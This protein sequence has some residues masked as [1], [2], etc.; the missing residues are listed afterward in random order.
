[1]ASLGYDPWQSEYLSERLRKQNVP[2]LAVQFIS[3]NLQSMAQAML[4]S[5]NQHNIDLYD[6]PRLISDLR[7]LRVADRGYGVRLESPRGPSGHGDAA[8]ALA[9][10][11]HLARSRSAFTM[12]R[13]SDK[14]LAY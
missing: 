9:I 12:H 1:L 7:A 4:E 8:I 3:G 6:N 10:A 5:F 2:V 13:E 11:L 14:L